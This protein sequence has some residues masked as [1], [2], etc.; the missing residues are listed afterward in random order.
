MPQIYQAIDLM[1]RTLV[2]TLAVTN[3]VKQRIYPESLPTVRRPSY[4]CVT[5][6]LSASDTAGRMK[7]I[8]VNMI[9]IRTWSDKSYKEANQVFKT[10]MDALYAQRLQDTNYYLILEQA[11]GV[12]WVPVP[13]DPEPL[14]S[15]LQVFEVTSFER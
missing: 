14:Y 1:K 8:N 12:R 15:T 5:F 2:G 7:E 3:L 10:V 6:E 13:S 9:T 4:P 11:S